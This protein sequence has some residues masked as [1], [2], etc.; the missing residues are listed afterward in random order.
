MD[1]E[2]TTVF[3]EEDGIE[4]AW[5]AIDVFVM[6]GKTYLLL[7]PRDEDDLDDK[8][9]ECYDNHAHRK[10]GQ[11]RDPGERRRDGSGHNERTIVY[12][13]RHDGDGDMD[14]G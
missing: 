11:H 9:S 13:K 5:D 10:D 3:L 14:D 2:D 6:E 8:G 4:R 7:V 1:D 12:D